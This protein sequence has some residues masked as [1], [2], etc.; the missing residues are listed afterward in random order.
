MILFVAGTGTGVGKTVVSAALLSGL[1][2]HGHK[3][4]YCK[5]IQTGPLNEDARMVAELS[6]C[7]TLPT[8]FNFPLPMSP[9]QAAHLYRSQNL[10][11]VQPPLTV[12][13]LK[14][15]L[16]E[17]SAQ[18]EILL[19]EA[20]GGLMV[21]LNEFGE[22]WL[23]LLTLL[24]DCY[25]VLV[26]HSQLG[27][28]NHSRLSL[29]A[30]RL[31][32]L[33]V[34]SLVLSG[35]KH[36]YNE[37]SLRRDCPDVPVLN[38]L[39][40]DLSSRTK[41]PIQARE[42]AN[43]VYGEY[44]RLQIIRKENSAALQNL[45]LDVVWHPFTQHKKLTSPLQVV[46]ARDV[47]LELS[48]GT[49]LIDGISS[50]WVNTIGHGRTEISQAIAQ[51]QQTLDHVLFAGV[52]HPPAVTLA[53]S[54]VHWAGPPFRKV[55]YSDNGS[56]S[57][58]VALKMAFQACRQ[59][60]YSQRTRIL[61]VRGSYH[62]DT[63]GAMSVAAAT[64]FHDPFQRLFFPCLFVS[65]LTSHRSVYCPD[66]G[67]HREE[68]LQELENLFAEHGNELCAVIVE[69]LLQGA[70][71]MLVQDLH[72][73]RKLCE[74][75]RRS[76]ALLIFDEVFT[77]L[78]R[79]GERFAFQRLG[80][81]PDLLCIAKGLTGGNLSLAATLATQDIFDAF[82]ADDSQQAF[83]HGHSYTANPIA[84][85]AANVALGIIEKEGL[86]ANALRLQQGYQQW[87]DTVGVELSVE[88]GRALGGVM[89]FELQGTGS[90]SYF[91]ENG[92]SRLIDEAF[93]QGLFLR[94]LGNTCYLAPP[95]VMKKS[96]QETM[97]ARL[98]RALQTLKVR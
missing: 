84:C 82:L 42:L 59:R 97:L 26:G 9:D 67:E 48:D 57:V 53:Q 32:G 63:V 65:P 78:G 49:R 77:G 46:R 88:N 83:L 34:L 54:L 81:A 35:E 27:T 14:E 89:A 19:V 3:V 28:L 95:L 41:L 66:G 93:S 40:C 69:P 15:H 33:R 73:L 90:S 23:S 2:Q 85:A 60:G 24:D 64:G 62:G 21:P 38:F 68:R 55:F 30:L 1:T 74:L 94:P 6:G 44:Q 17:L 25:V 37:H 80:L 31:R 36:E 22:T 7:P 10:S 87:L 92:R 98:T 11:D 71:G 91:K 58:E 72:W 16:T 20:A 43:F 8:L 79:L 86:C 4:A 45:D 51:Q 70:G 39:H 75:T 5:P 52:T 12:E 50:W 56:T 18:H 47:F 61:A 29:D 76:G 96:Q 13:C